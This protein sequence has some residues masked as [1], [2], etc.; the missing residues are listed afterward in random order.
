MRRRGERGQSLVEFALILPI[1]LLLLV[2]IFDLG[3]V[4]WS[5]DALTN[6]ARE[7]A[8]FAIV[9]GNQA[10][11]PASRQDVKNAAI[12]WAANVGT[13]VS[14][15]VCW[16]APGLPCSGDT[17]TGT[18][19]RGQLVTVTVTANVRLAAPSFFG[20]GGFPLSSTTTM[21]VNH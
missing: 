5:N 21:L 8:R 15:T 3:H 13:N 17:D 14:A 20:F 18:A 7:A 16:S 11:T 4:V 2:G 10:Q 19:D 1:F 9:N 6:A 12:N